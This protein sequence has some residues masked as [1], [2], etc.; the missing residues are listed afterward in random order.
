MLPHAAR[1]TSVVE[2]SPQGSFRTLAQPRVLSREEY[3]HGVRTSVVWLLFA[4]VAA[5]LV[6]GL[7]SSTA[8]ART[9]RTATLCRRPTV[10][11]DP[12][13]LLPLTANPIGPSANAALRYAR[14][15]KPQVVAADL[16]TGDHQRGGEAKFEC[17]TRVWRRSVVVY[18][19]LR[20][21]LPSASLSQRVFFVGR[22]K[23]G[24]RVWQL[25]H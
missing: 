12:R 24:Y 13:G 9:P 22:F 8:D 18:V 7:A 4:G 6:A 17:G 19:T 1:G 14:S 16:A 23:Q 3:S 15:G 5:S 11:I 25:V 21:Y 20:A 10:E 2:P